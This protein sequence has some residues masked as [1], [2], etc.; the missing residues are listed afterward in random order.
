[1]PGFLAVYTMKPEDLARF[2]ALPKT[3][4]KAVDDA[5]AAAAFTRV[6]GTCKPCHDAHREKSA[7][8]KYHVK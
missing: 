2:R 8:G 4:Q 5:K 7:D 3:E 1:M 6:G